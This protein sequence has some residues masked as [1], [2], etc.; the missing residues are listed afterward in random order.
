MI[1]D[2]R[3]ALFPKDIRQF[4]I[5]PSDFGALFRRLRI[6][7]FTTRGVRSEHKIVADRAGLVQV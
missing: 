5:F 4:H 2:A 6:Q 3:D 7:S 1:D